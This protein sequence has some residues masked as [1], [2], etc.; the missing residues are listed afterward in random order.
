MEF[1]TVI[2]VVLAS[3]FLVFCLVCLALVCY[4]ERKVKAEDEQ[5]EKDVED[6]KAKINNTH[7]NTGNLRCGGLTYVREETVAEVHK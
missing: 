6:N 7:T 2:I 1:L 3:S 4:F 5:Y